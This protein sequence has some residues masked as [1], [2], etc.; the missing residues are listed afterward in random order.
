MCA[1]QSATQVPTKEDLEHAIMAWDR[2]FL[3][4]NNDSE[5]ALSP[6]KDIP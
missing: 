5:A 3:E 6:Q 1:G 2:A 4:F